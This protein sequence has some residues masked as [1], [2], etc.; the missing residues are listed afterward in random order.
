MIIVPV[1]SDRSDVR[2]CMVM[3]GSRLEGKVAFITGVA[4]GQGRAHAVRMAEEGADIIGID[5][6]E[7][8]ESVNYPLATEE[9]LLETQQLVEKQ[10]RRMVA[11]V[12]DVRERAEL[13]DA[14]DAGLAELGRL[15]VVVAQAG[16]C[17]MFPRDNPMDF[18]DAADVDLAGVLNT[19]GVSFPHLADGSS[20]ILTGSV[21]AMVPNTTEGQ[22][23]GAGY[24]WAKRSLMG[25]TEQ[26]AN[27]CGSRMIRVNC[28]HPTNCDTPLLHNDL[29]Y[30]LF[31]PDLENPTREQVEPRFN[32]IHAMP[33]P[34]VDPV[35]IANLGV[36]LAS[37]ESRYVT[38]QQI[39]VDMGCLVKNGVVRS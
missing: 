29:I 3:S 31:A 30:G 15:D 5:I 14:L 28:I 24:A 35:D 38:G 4:R 18:L 1:N 22:A 7:Q 16:I 32:F 33:R 37:D 23:G 25:L 39:R 9:D 6:C 11:R 13:R 20:I 8:I 34:H 10:G 19:I 2:G 27:H 36:F 17:P 12:A 21:A 26:L